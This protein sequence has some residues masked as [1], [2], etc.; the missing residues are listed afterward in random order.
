MFFSRFKS[1]H[2]KMSKCVI[3]VAKW[4]IFIRN[5]SHLTFMFFSST[6]STFWVL[7]QSSFIVLVNDVALLN[8]IGLLYN[9]KTCNLNAKLSRLRWAGYEYWTWAEKHPDRDTQTTQFRQMDSDDRRWRQLAQCFVHRR[10]LLS[11]VLNLQLVYFCLVRENRCYFMNEIS[12][13]CKA[14]TMKN[15]VDV[16][17]TSGGARMSN[18]ALT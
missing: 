3:Y 4:Q 14:P 10:I 15:N 9:E 16:A 6:T 7:P 17:L 11:A 2:F 18:N 5:I 8:S 1:S 12:T 13:H